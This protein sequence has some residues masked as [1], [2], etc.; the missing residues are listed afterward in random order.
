M[1]RRGEGGSRVLGGTYH[2]M[3]SLEVDR[4]QNQLAHSLSNVYR[5]KG[6]SLQLKAYKAAACQAV[7]ELEV[8]FGAEHAKLENLEDNQIGSNHRS[9]KCLLLR[10]YSWCCNM[11]SNN[12]SSFA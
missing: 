1:D 12:L 7:D 10:P 9:V 5:L 8:G 6:S 2:Q 11:D 3:R 4:G